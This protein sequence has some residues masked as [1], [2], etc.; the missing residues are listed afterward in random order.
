MKVEFYRHG[1]GEEELAAVSRVMSGLFLTAGPET[2]RFEEAFAD[3]LGVARVVGLFSCTSA[4][5]LA[6]RALGV[7]PGD[8]VITTPLS[9][10][11][12]ANAVV[13]AGGKP[14]FAEVEAATGLLDPAAVEAAITPRTQG[15]LPVHL[16]GQM[17]DMHRLRRIADRHGLFLLEDAAHC[18][19]GRRD[20]VG[21]GQLGDGACF[22]FY[23]T[24]NLHAG[25]GGA[26]A[27]RNQQLA[28]Q[29]LLMRSHGMN[30]EAADRYHGPYRHWDMVTFGHK[31][32]MFDLQAALLLPQL[33]KL[34]PRLAQRQALCRVYEE[35]LAGLPEVQWPQSLPE[36]VHARHLFTLWTRPRWRDGLLAGL[37]KAGVG[38]AVNFRPIHLM[39]WYR[40]TFDT[41]RGM[42]PVA[43]SIGD[44]TLSLPLWPDLPLAEQQYVI[45][46]VKQGLERLSRS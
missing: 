15:I 11:A 6:L 14:V 46:G 33:P 40:E 26:L 16:Y 20:G 31:A 1:L 9:F 35:A 36:V 39:T 2:R 44:R 8:E 41:C 23:A 7:G 24:K 29:V 30:K 3:Y 13:E 12:S 37:N 45:L 10:I 43:E 19:E 38:C 21:P 18:V 28:N 42:F 25:E 22:S 5:V 34:A 17:C 32:N 4:L 27:T